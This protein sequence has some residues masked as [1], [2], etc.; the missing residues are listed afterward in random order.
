MNYFTKK[1]LITWAVTALII[2]NITSLVTIWMQ[3]HRP[4]RPP[5]H[6][7]PEDAKE[8]TI[9]FLKQELQFS[10]EQVYKFIE[11]QDEYLKNSVHF[12]RKIGD[13]KRELF[14]G[15]MDNK[16][17]DKDKL[18]ADIGRLNSQREELTYKHFQ[19]MKNLCNENQQKKYKMLMGRILMRIDPMHLKPERGQNPRPSDHPGNRPGQM[20]PPPPGEGQRPPRNQR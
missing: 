3:Q 15:L 2:I 10:N 12:Q 7:L 16:S 19:N 6:E 20:P 11:L 9:I 18:I 4:M 1:R 17:V 13:T 8:A 14:S 5:H